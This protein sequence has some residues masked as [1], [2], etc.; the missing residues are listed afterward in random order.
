MYTLIENQSHEY[1]NDINNRL[2]TCMMA[3]DTGVGGGGGEG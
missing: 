3:M 2:Y 1:N